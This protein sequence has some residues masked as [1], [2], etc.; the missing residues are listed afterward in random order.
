VTRETGNLFRERRQRRNG[1]GSYGR[2]RPRR[3]TVTRGDDVSTT[4]VGPTHS[5]APSSTRQR[6]RWTAARQPVHRPDNSGRHTVQQRHTLGGSASARPSGNSDSHSDSQSDSLSDNLVD[7]YWGTLIHPLSS[8]SGAQF[9]LHC[10]SVTR[11][12]H[13]LL[14][15][16]VLRRCSQL[17]ILWLSLSLS[18]SHL[19]TQSDSL[20]PDALVHAHL[21]GHMKFSRLPDQAAARERE[22]KDT[23]CEAAVN[24]PE[25]DRSK[26]NRCTR[27]GRSKDRAGP[28][29]TG[30]NGE[31]VT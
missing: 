25:N 12:S 30:H 11:P 26:V 27:N 6:R 4:S 23:N 21:P 16:N 20:A 15:Q 19:S 5:V 1:S 8:A 29:V 22:D 10:V 28:T 9:Y 13:S 31:S 2:K 17:S 7:D 24:V 14:T 18:V 3:G